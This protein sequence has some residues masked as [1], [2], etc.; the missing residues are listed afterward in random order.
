MNVNCHDNVT[1]NNNSSGIFYEISYGGTIIEHN[2]SFND[3]MGDAAAAPGSGGLNPPF[4]NDA[5]LISCSPSDAT[6]SVPPAGPNTTSE[7]RYNWID[8][9]GGGG[10]IGLLD[11]SG[12]PSGLRTRNWSVHH[13]LVY[14]RGPAISSLARSGLFDPSNLNLI[15]L[16][17]A[18]NHFDAD[19]YHVLTPGGAYY[20]AD[21]SK[22]FT[23][24]RAAGYEA[25][26]TEAGL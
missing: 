14:T 11:H 23:T 17:G 10:G 26:G 1:E 15:T 2:Y 22:T 21:G 24:F 8:T 20:D 7:V 18:N 6:G 16:A 4:G 19:E 25:S 3:G 9:S 5:I 12:H 13:N